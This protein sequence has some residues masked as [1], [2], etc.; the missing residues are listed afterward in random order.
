MR[1]KI[2]LLTRVYQAKI[3]ALDGC[4]ADSKVML[5]EVDRKLFRRPYVYLTCN[6]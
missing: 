1:N 3:T 6:P 5:S 2:F 4:Q